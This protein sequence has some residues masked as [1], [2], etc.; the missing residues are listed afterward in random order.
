MKKP[1]IAVIAAMLIGCVN[2]A[3]ATVS[4]TYDR[5]TDA[6]ALVAR[7]AIESSLEKYKDDNISARVYTV[8]ELNTYV[9]NGLYVQIIRDRDHCQFTP[10]IED[11]ARIVG[12]PAFEFVW[13]DMLINGYCVQQDIELGIDYLQRSVNH[14]YPP[15]MIHAAQY[16][17][18]GRLL[19]RDKGKAVSLMRAAA[20]L[21]SREARMEW[22]DMLVRGL[23]APSYYEE[24]YSWL[25]H[26]I[27]FKEYEKAKSEYLLAAMRKLMPANIVARAMSDDYYDM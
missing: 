19:P 2:C 5:V 9:D 18:S 7:K 11:R 4:S 10:D 26:S 24:A 27:F 25:Y 3:W 13:A 17:E 12:M 14:A 8:D 22:V 23:G 15:A 20:A 16:Y 21:G 6:Q 1:W